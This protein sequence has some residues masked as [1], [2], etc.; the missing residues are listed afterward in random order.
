[1]ELL[2]YGHNWKGIDYVLLKRY[3]QA[4]YHFEKGL[5]MEP[6]IPVGPYDAICMNLGWIYDHIRDDL[7]QSERYY[8]LVR[9]RFLQGIGGR[10]VLR[11]IKINE[12]LGILYVRFE[13]RE[14]AL[15]HGLEAKRLLKDYKKSAH[16]YQQRD[17]LVHHILGEA[18]KG[19][20]RLDTAMV[21]LNYC[22]TMQHEQTNKNAL[23]ISRIYGTIGDVYRQKEDFE[24]ALQNDRLAVEWALKI[25]DI[26]QLFKQKEIAGCYNNLAATIA[27]MGN[28]EEA[29]RIQ[30]KCLA[31]SFAGYRPADFLELPNPDSL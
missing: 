3:D 6:E 1:M 30:Q 15:R 22:L 28:Q 13:L 25:P 27:L 4:L 17:Y 8:Q 9:N 21:C 24:S 29:L 10:G 16:D 31:T 7:Y 14:K 23:N 20:G 2:I 5:S 19:L 18:Y 12:A 11:G 26:H